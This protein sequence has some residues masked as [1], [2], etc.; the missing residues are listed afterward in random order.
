MLH[1]HH[2]ARQRWDLLTVIIITYSA[3]AIPF[4]VSFTAS[5]ERPVWFEAFKY[6]TALVTGDLV[7]PVH[8]HHHMS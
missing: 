4:E 1:P 2:K 6:V 5:Q 7:S 3:F 8:D